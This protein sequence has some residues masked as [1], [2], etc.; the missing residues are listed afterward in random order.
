MI[1]YFIFFYFRGQIP[2]GPFTPQSTLKGHT[3]TVRVVKFSPH[4]AILASGGSGDCKIRVWD[5]NQSKF[6]LIF[7]VMML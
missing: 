5:V 2:S 3:G 7:I 1:V 4:P 6:R